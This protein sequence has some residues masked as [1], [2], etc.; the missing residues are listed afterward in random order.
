MD[1]V[2]HHDERL[3]GR[4]LF[5]ELANAPKQLC[6]RILGR[7]QADRR[8]YS[9]GDPRSVGCSFANQSEDLVTGN[10][11]WI[12]RPDARGLAGDVDKLPEREARAVRQASPF[13]HVSLDGGA[14]D[15]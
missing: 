1:V 3:A 14:L 12:L 11:G 2:D 8:R 15:E 13:E 7:R 5:E 10:L 4:E 6:D 9:V